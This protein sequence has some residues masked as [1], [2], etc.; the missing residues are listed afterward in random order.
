MIYNVGDVLILKKNHVCGSNQWKVLR[1]GIEIKLECI[2]CH[3][4]ILIMK[5]DLDK[6]VKSPKKTV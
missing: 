3:R 5:K 6:K 4:T 2:K 1:L